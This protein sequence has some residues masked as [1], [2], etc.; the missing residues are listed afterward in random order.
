MQRLDKVLSLKAD[1]IQG[2]KM[3]GDA[4]GI[5][6][7]DSWDDVIF[8]DA[9]SADVIADFLSSGFVADAHDWTKMVGMPL[10]A[11]VRGN[12]LY[13]ECE[14]HSTPDAQIIK[15]KCAER[16]ARGLAVGLSVGIGMY[17][18]S[19]KSFP[20]GPALLAYAEAQGY[21]MTLFD[22]EGIKAHTRRCRAIVHVDKW[23]EY[24]PVPVPANPNAWASAMK[25]AELSLATKGEYFG[26]YMEASMTMA[27]LYRLTDALYYNIFWDCVYYASD[28]PLEERRKTL[29]GALAEYSAIVLRVFDALITEDEESAETTDEALKA[30]KTLWSDPKTSSPETLPVGISF[31]NQLKS[32]LAAV[33]GCTERAQAI[34]TL[35]AKEGRAFS[36]TR[37]QEIAAQREAL[38]GC[39]KSLD[40]ILAPSENETATAETAARL[41]ALRARQLARKSQRREPLLGEV[42]S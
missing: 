39:I 18:D 41:I 26:D 30:I 19:I 31:D 32:A 22:V 37:R 7:L 4:G 34:L 15:T 11:E 38:A 20:N 12:L 25:H 10:V 42:E 1:A 29:E 6:N 13:T 5:G 40:D 33:Q 36:D 21:D 8:P 14:F 16:I 17:P 9:F 35:R 27:A 23:Y 3:A 24:S 28:Y 2:D